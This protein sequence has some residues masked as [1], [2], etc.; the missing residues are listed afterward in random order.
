MPKINLILLASVL[1][2][3]LAGAEA[4]TERSTKSADLRVSLGHGDLAIFSDK[5]PVQSLET[6]MAAV[7]GQ[8]LFVNRSYELSPGLISRFEW[9]YKNS[10]YVLEIRPGTKFHNG[11]EATA[12]DLE[13]SILRGLISKRAAWAKSFF[14]NIEGIEAAENASSFKSGMV[15]GI[16]PLDRRRLR[17]RLSAPNPSFLH[18]LARSYFSLVPQEALLPD[19]YTWKNLPLGAGP[20]K[21]TSLN[22]NRSTAT[23]ER[24]D[25]SAG[26][27]AR[28]I[29]SSASDFKNPDVSI[30]EVAG[31]LDT[32]NLSTVASVTGIY[33]NYDN[34]LGSNPNFRK[35]VSLSIKRRP[36]ISGVESYAMASELL[37]SPFWGR[38][39]CGG[40]FSASESTARLKSLPIPKKLVIPVFNSSF[41]DKNLGRYLDVLKEQFAAVGLNV[42]F[43]GSDK[44]FFDKSDK[45]V[46]LRILSL[47]ADLADPLVLFGL[48]RAGSPMVPHFPA[49]DQEFDRLYLAAAKASSLDKKSAAVKALSQYFVENVFAV[50]L[51]ERRALIGVNGKKIKSIGNQDGGNAIYLERFVLK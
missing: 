11:R 26:G 15:S 22:A 2:I 9:D 1:L 10:W 45:D 29:V 8:L 36:L 50:P 51:F 44:K 32:E 27:P 23:L 37:P 4:V 6:V 46:P 31:G 5:Q 18:S 20:Y 43:V 33:F 35:A 30:N 39:T 49:K 14:A 16:K 34:E 25:S 3:N 38:C 17:I 7:F 42:S 13:F 19:L 28:L 40:K 48:F 41:G 24:V 12:T 47:G 21:V